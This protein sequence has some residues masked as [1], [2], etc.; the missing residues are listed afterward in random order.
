MNHD[1]IKG[2]TRLHAPPEDEGLN[3]SFLGIPTASI[4]AWETLQGFFARGEVTPCH[5][6][7]EWTSNR[8]TDKET[9]KRLC[10]DCVCRAACHEYAESAQEQHGTWAGIDRSKK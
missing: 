10:G 4:D 1:N 9:A 7:P 2:T 6:R 8:K 3:L 5:S